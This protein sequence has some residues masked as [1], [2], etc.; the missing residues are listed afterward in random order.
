[1]TRSFRPIVFVF[2]I[3]FF[4]VMEGCYKSNRLKGLVPGHGVV[5]HEEK[6]L[7]E[8]QIT[9]H[10]KTGTESLRGAYAE[11]DANGRFKL[12]T[13]HPQDG[14]EPGA[15]VV[16]VEKTEKRAKMDPETALKITAGEIRG[17]DSL[18]EKPPKSLIDPRFADRETSGIEIEIDRKGNK[19]IEIRLE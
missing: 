9:F 16:T 17:P 12:S 7:S 4:C 19:S 6:P 15:Y 18:T 2:L 13:L 10:P 3:A 5:I 14:I 1:M 8:A 11:T